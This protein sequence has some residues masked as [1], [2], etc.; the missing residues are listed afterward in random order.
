M[1][2]VENFRRHV[3]ERINPFV[4]GQRVVAGPKRESANRLPD[5]DHT[6][7]A[8]KGWLREAEK[9]CRVET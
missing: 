6:A 7:Q 3:L 4:A 9:A 1:L 8:Y 5:Q 2:Q